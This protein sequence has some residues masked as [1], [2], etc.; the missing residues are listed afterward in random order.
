MAAEKAYT[1]GSKVN[2]NGSTSLHWTRKCHLTTKKQNQHQYH[3]PTHIFCRS[4]IM[5]PMNI[6]ITTVWWTGPTNSNGQP[7]P[8]QQ[9]ILCTKHGS[10]Q[11]CMWFYQTVKMKTKLMFIKAQT[12][13]MMTRTSSGNM[14]CSAWWLTA[15]VVNSKHYT[16]FPIWVLHVI[17]PEPWPFY[18]VN[19][20]CVCTGTM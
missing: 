16:A 3:M 19:V 14:P 13:G 20:N 5:Q 9:S 18:T 4:S 11:F 12:L 17:T 8:V 10:L 15:L 1:N 6:Y 7:G 2:E